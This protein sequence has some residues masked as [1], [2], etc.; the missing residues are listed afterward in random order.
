MTVHSD[1]GLMSGG[2]AARK[3]SVH[4][5]APALA[6]SQRSKIDS[7]VML[8]I[9]PSDVPLPFAWVYLVHVS[10]CFGPFPRSLVLRVD[11]L[12]GPCPRPGGHPPFAFFCSEVGR[13]SSR[14]LFSNCS[15]KAA[16]LLLR[17]RSFRTPY[18]VEVIGDHR[19]AHDLLCNLC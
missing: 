18:D 3:P 1:V 10:G 17:S 15:R 13:S 6:I 19:L 2:E 11:A 9:I 8:T 4:E 7:A 14:A 5:V 12:E 16:D